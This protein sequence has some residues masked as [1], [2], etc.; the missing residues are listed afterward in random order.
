MMMALH[1]S[2]AQG[3]VAPRMRESRGRV[4]VES[5]AAVTLPCVAQGH[6]PPSYRL[7]QPYPPPSLPLPLPLPAVPFHDV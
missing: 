5:G 1:V 6:P 2:E 4:V 3:A 7:V